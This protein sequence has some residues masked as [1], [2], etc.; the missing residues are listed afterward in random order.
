MNQTSLKQKSYCYDSLQAIN[1]KVNS[2]AGTFES[3]YSLYTITKIKIIR[4]RVIGDGC[5]WEVISPMNL[6]ESVSQCSIM[7]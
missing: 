6:A 3:S 5:I 4:H 7:F 2:L 1:D